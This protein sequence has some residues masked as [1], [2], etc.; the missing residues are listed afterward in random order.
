[1]SSSSKP[2][3]RYCAP[4]NPC[5]VKSACYDT[6]PFRHGMYEEA[7]DTHHLHLP[8]FIF[9]DCIDN[10]A[11]FKICTSRTSQERPLVRKQEAVSERF[12]GFCF[13]SR[14]LATTSIDRISLRRR[15][16][17]ANCYAAIDMRIW[18]KFLGRRYADTVLFMYTVPNDS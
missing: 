7:A 4:W 2:R 15:R 12:V 3:T 13:N 1:M 18:R 5:S 9:A 6:Q 8:E 14:R 16:K 11:S 17:E 10:V